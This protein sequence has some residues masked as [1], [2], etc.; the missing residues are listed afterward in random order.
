MVLIGGEFSA[1]LITQNL[2]VQEQDLCVVLFGLPDLSSC[3][4]QI[5]PHT[6]YYNSRCSCPSFIVLLLQT[7]PSVLKRAV[8]STSTVFM[9]LH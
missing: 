5:I 4:G 7:E 6:K 1:Y 9:L 2:R 8:T 3:P